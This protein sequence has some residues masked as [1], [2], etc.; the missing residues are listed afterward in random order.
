MPN[1]RIKNGNDPNQTL[2]TV[3]LAPH[4]S[5][6][7][8]IPLKNT[9]QLLHLEPPRGTA[10]HVALVASTPAGGDLLQQVKTLA[11]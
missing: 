2:L 9:K 8:N 7:L 3:E 6:T 11:Y 1:T 10:I 4:Q 5:V